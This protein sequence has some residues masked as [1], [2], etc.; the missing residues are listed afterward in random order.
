[1]KKTVYLERWKAAGS[2]LGLLL[3]GVL[4]GCKETWHVVAELRFGEDQCLYLCVPL[5]SS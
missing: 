3:L 4:P 1:M 2:F 5:S